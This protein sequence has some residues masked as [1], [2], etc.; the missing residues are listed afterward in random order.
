MDEPHLGEAL[1]PDLPLLA[2]QVP[3]ALSD[4]C[5]CTLPDLLRRLDLPLLDAPLART[6]LPDLAEAMAAAQGWSVGETQ[7]QVQAAEAALEGPLSAIGG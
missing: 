1:S 6:L 5:V 4:E 3:W 2:A 7:G